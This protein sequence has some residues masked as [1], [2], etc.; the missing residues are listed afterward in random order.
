MD[1]YVCIHG[2]FYQPPRENP[3]L[4]AIEL[5]DSAYPYHD[6]NERINAVCYA[7]NAI[8]RILDSEGR[9]VKFR[10]N[11]NMISFNF[12]PTLLAWLADKD[13]QTYNAILAADRRSQQNFGG[14]GSALA[15]AYNHLIMPLA[16]R[17]DKYTQVWWGI[18]DFEHRF[19]RRPEGMWLPETAVD[20][21]TLDI[22]AEQGISFTVLAPH[23]AARVREIGQEAW[24]EV[25]GGAVDPTKA[26]RLTLPSGRSINLFFY[27]AP[28]SRGV[29]FENLLNRGEDLANRLVGAFSEERHDPQLVHI[30]T[31]GETYGHH[32]RY[33]D[34]ALAYAL[35]YIE[36]KGLARLTNYGEF[37]EKHPPVF[38]V[39]IFENTSWSCAH[40]VERWRNDCGCH[41]GQHPGWHQAWRAPLRE[42]L[43]W[44]RDSLAPLF[45]KEAG[46][47]LRDPWE[48]RNDY[49]AVILDRSP[50]NVA[51]FLK[52]HARR[53][54]DEEQKIKVLK[55]LESQRH[56][57][58]MYT[59]CGW[60]FDE[61]SG[62][63]TVQVMQYAGRVIQ[64]A[65][66]FEG[67]DLES[68]FLERLQQAPSNLPEHG[69]G[70]RIY[71]KFVK[72]A[73]VDLL[74]VGAH[75]ALS[76]FFEDYKPRDRIYC[77]RIDQE[78]LRSSEIGNAKLEVG[79][80]KVASEITGSASVISF[81]ALYLGDHNLC[82]GLR[83]FL[84]EE[85]YG[86][87]AWEITEAFSWA[88]FPE[89]IRRIGLH[90]GDRFY[91]PRSLFRDEQ[92]KVLDQISEPAQKTARNAYRQLYQQNLPF[93]RFLIELGIPLPKVLRVTADYVCNLNLRQ[94]FEDYKIDLPELRSLMEEARFLGV[95]LDAAGLEFALR[96]TLDNLAEKFRENPGDLDLLLQLD[97]R[98]TLA[99]ELPFEVNLW[100]LQNVYYEVLLG[101]Y[102]EQ[103]Q[104]AEQN[105]L[106]A[107][108]WLG[109]FIA[110]GEKLSIKV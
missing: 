89:T 83:E 65:R 81:A 94:A 28:I 13:P 80:I 21:E 86:T 106:E 77:Y 62:L 74:A 51:E 107:Q 100:K 68:P 97:V 55:L 12:G 29:A 78:D 27:D 70:R 18:R 46:E 16:N 82:A 98:A 110:L 109:Y 33:G 57:L 42:A 9:I 2:H 85:A 58:L 7:P 47:L 103:R 61:L 102:P 101:F 37:L 99:Q 39:E 36:S 76:F 10:N 67:Q 87:M 53:A 22:M 104:K 95:Q 50:D 105:L 1:R 79:R 69:D 35:E 43:D 8:C 54:L 73:M 41:S 88:D 66:A 14:H 52:R 108:E 4:E 48:A 45:E 30:A 96:R 56:A 23:Q 72:P 15:Q 92:R 64:L 38:E 93:M 31:D 40:G 59:S 20:L 63:E 84:S 19:G 60:F 26:Y 3:W 75:Y 11:Y 71:E 6:W 49:I 91:S 24:R 25:S 44:L 90:F 17:R 5:Q 34:M 32:H